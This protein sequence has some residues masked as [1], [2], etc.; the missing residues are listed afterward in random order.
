M[1]KIENN[2]NVY[3]NKKTMSS[4]VVLPNILTNFRDDQIIIDDFNIGNYYE[5]N[6]KKG[7]YINKIVGKIC[8]SK[9]SSITCD[10]KGYIYKEFKSFFN[11][12]PNKLW[13][14]TNKIRENKDMYAS[15]SINEFEVNSEIIFCTIDEYLGIVGNFES[16]YEIIKFLITK[17]W[18]KKIDKL[19]LN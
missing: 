16:D 11:I 12:F 1:L 10:Q 13:V 15:I 2:Y 7:N 18:S 3:L 4:V 17:H 8:F 9:S 6:K 5:N 14:K 19:S